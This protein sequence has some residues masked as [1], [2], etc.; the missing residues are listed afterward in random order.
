MKFKNPMLVVKDM[1]NAK[2][3]YHNVLGLRVI[4]DLGEN[5]TL[6]GGISLQTEKVILDG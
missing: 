6:T 5:V 2:Q 1:N 4:S 3:F